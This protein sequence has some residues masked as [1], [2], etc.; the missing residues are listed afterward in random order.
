MLKN[1][2]ERRPSM[3]MN[4]WEFARKSYDTMMGCLVPRL[5]AGTLD[6]ALGSVN[7]LIALHRGGAWAKNP[8]PRD[9]VG[10]TPDRQVVYA[11]SGNFGHYVAKPYQD[12]RNSLQRHAWPNYEHLGRQLDNLDLSK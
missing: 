8:N 2:Q 6:T 9:I 5:T 10:I 11:E 7:T 3:S 1:H 4:E 12:V